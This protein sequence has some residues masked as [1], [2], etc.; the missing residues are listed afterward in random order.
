MNWK[1]KI[2]KLIVIKKELIKLDTEGLWDFY[3]PEDAGSEKELGAVEEYL[4]YELDKEYKDFLRCANGWKSI[5]QSIDLF[6]TNELIASKEIYDTDMLMTTLSP[7]GAF[8]AAGLS[9]NELLPIAANKDTT[10]LFVITK[11]Y[12][13]NPG[14]VIWFAGYEIERYDS[15]QKFFSAINKYNELQLVNLKQSL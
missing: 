15:F 3:E 5:F 7:E 11:K 1:D 14:M 13:N 12:S 4:K 2:K 10:D 9:E 6:G 8:Q